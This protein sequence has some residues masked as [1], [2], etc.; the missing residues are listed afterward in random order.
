MGWG[1]CGLDSKGRP[2]GYLFEA[3]CDYEGCD[4]KIDRGLSYACGGMHG[5]ATGYDCEGYF[6]DKHMSCG[7]EIPDVECPQL[8]LNCEARLILD[9]DL[10]VVGVKDDIFIEDISDGRIGISWSDTFGGS[11]TG[12]FF[13]KDCSVIL[14]SENDTPIP[15]DVLRYIVGLLDGYKED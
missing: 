8:C 5:E 11:G 14:H 15:L 2:I 12:T 10:T 1:D 4:E 6:C 13:T 9:D 7:F 3:T